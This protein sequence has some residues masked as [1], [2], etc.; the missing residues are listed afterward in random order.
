MKHHYE[1]R[2][3]TLRHEGSCYAIPMLSWAETMAEAKICEDAV[4]R[5]AMKRDLDDFQC[6]QSHVGTSKAFV[7]RKSGSVPIRLSKAAKRDLTG[8]V[9]VEIKSYSDEGIPV[10][11]EPTLCSVDDIHVDVYTHLE[12]DVLLPERSIVATVTPVIQ[13]M[14]CLSDTPVE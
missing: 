7:L 11:F 10:T 2:L 3:I 5:K 12:G 1:Q 4:V 6:I 9:K 13:S 14:V 8:L